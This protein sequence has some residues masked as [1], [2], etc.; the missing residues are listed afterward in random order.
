MLPQKRTAPQDHPE[1]QERSKR[2]KTGHSP[3]KSPTDKALDII[4]GIYWDVNCATRFRTIMRNSSSVS[5]EDHA[6]HHDINHDALAFLANFVHDHLTAP[7][8]GTDAFT[9][10]RCLSFLRQFGWQMFSICAH[11]EAF[12]RACMK[13]ANIRYDDEHWDALRTAIANN[14]RSLQVFARTR[15]LDWRGPLL[16]FSQYDMLNVPYLPD[17]LSAEI[18]LAKEHHHHTVRML[19]GHLRR[20]RYQHKTQIN[21]SEQVWDAEANADEFYPMFRDKTWGKCGHCGCSLNE[22]CQCRTVAMGGD[23][24]ELTEYP[25]KGIGVRVLS[26][27]R[28][29]DIVDQYLGEILPVYQ[30]L[31]E[32][33]YSL[34]QEIKVDGEWVEISFIEPRRLGNWTRFMNHSCDSKSDFVT[35]VAGPEITTVVKMRKD[36]SLFEEMTVN[37]GP[38]YWKSSQCP[39]GSGDCVS[40]LT[41]SM[42]EAVFH[43]I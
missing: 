25:N 18:T 24:V 23:M 20:P 37:Y 7:V 35:L 40:R 34:T 39:C 38:N 19:N 2:N 32:S 22:P 26:K 42:I 30:P 21:V 16:K 1:S 3:R 31:P 6:C 9:Y 28:D 41:S 10:G 13:D 12:R 33:V 29:G 15:G 43:G 4:A 36:V 5:I 8:S 14:G 11:S 17:E 27:F